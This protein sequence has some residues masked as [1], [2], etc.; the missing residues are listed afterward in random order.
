MSEPAVPSQRPESPR[1]APERVLTVSGLLRSVRDVIERQLPLAW[2][3]GELSNFTAARSGHWYFIL[4]DA[5]AQVR[6]VMFRG[7]NQYLD[8]QPADGMQVDLR[9]LPT[10]YEARGEFQLTVETMRRS[11]LGALFERF[12]KLRDRL[13]EEG[14]FDP[15]LKRAIPTLPRRVGVI[16]STAGAAL[17]DVI[18]TMRRRNPS[19]ELI[20]YP[21]TVQG[22]RA[23]AELVA[24]LGRAGSRCEVDVLLLVRGGGSIE[25]L[26]CFND[27]SLARAIRACPI[28]VISGVG[29]ETDFTI[30]DFAADLRAP[31]PT[32]AAELVS[33]ARAELIAR[34]RDAFMRLQR[35]TRHRLH[36]QMQALDA[37]SHRLQHPAQ[38]LALQSHRLQCAIEA[39]RRLGAE[40]IVTGTL[41]LASLRQ[42]MTRSRPDLDRRQEALRRLGERL[43]RAASAQL[44]LREARLS[45]LAQALNH[46][47]PDQILARGFS[48]VFNADVRVVTDATQVNPGD[49]LTVQLARGRIVTQVNRTE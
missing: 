3:S 21:T 30:A 40:R 45:A 41:R 47:G 18:T 13:A 2:V 1:G 20:V 37:L 26:W 42:R 6:C 32:A 17:H 22:E 46:L 43:Q 29:H 35:S 7:R 24:A 8:W 10:L 25:D 34:A 19:I 48:I 4:K 28:P 11:G 33:P 39:L 36:S 27:E 16:S 12:L 15:A 14:L 31:T 23:A 5:Q 44:K 9:C 38:R 49:A